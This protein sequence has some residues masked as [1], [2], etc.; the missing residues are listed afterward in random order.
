MSSTIVITPEMSRQYHEEGYFLLERAVSS[1]HLQ[2]LRDEAASFID[3]I[4]AEMDRQGKDVIGINHR[5]KRYFINNRYRESEHLHEFLFS[6]LMADI[7]RATIGPNAYLFH[8]QYVIKAAEVGMKFAW[9]QDSGYVGVSHKPYL[10]CWC[11]LDDMT[12]ANGTV[13]ILPYSRAGGRDVVQHAR[14]A[15]SNDLVG[16]HGDDPGVPVLVPAGSIAVFSSVCFHRSGE[17]KTKAMR[18]V[19]LP[20][21]S[22]EPILNKDGT[23]PWALADPFLKNGAVVA[24][25]RR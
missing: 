14:E 16:Y 23:D 1:E 21:Y 4:H 7:C 3:K 8:E 6:D 10:T 15:G 19:Y 20:Q 22:S 2:M 18:R 24:A 5:N 17:N 25:A 12:E 11:A 13:Y 9:H